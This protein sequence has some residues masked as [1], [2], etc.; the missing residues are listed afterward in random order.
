[1][2]KKLI[3]IIL[4]SV[5]IGSTATAGYYF[6]KITNFCCTPETDKPLNYAENQKNEID[7]WKIYKNEYYGFE[8]KYPKE[9]QKKRK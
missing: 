8:I 9:W 2:N 1:M 6:I 5:A 3:L 4:T 7:I